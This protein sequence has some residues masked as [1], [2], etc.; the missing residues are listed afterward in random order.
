MIDS[1]LGDGPAEH[2]MDYVISYTLRSVNNKK[3]PHFASYCRRILFQLLGEEDK[4]E[5]IVDVR[6]WKQWKFTDLTAEIILKDALSRERKFALLVE[7]KYY[8]PVRRNRDGK[9]QTDIYK[10]RMEDHYRDTDFQLR[11][12][13]I[14]C[15]SHSQ[16]VFKSYDCVKASGY[17]VFSIYDVHET[18][19]PD[20]ESDIFN[21]FW[22]RSWS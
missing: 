6:V 3:M 19:Q 9:L 18:G 5:D 17:K 7:N 1:S 22:L 8:S 20:C 14:S 4:G 12:A 21:Q 2:I 16:D 13:L 15:C 11:Y 10:E